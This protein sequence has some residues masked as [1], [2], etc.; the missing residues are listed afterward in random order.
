MGMHDK[1]YWIWLLIPMVRIRGVDEFLVRLSVR[2]NYGVGLAGWIMKESWGLQRII[3]G[4]LTLFSATPISHLDV[5]LWMVSP[6]CC[7]C[8][9]NPSADSI[10]EGQYCMSKLLNKHSNCEL[11]ATPWWICVITIIRNV[12]TMVKQLLRI[13]P[14]ILHNV[15]SM[16]SVLRYK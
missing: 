10:Q 15:S 6:H 3:Y 11:V 4:S 14:S 12:S 1:M 16:M 7:P 8:E 2:S 13:Y 9:G 5:M